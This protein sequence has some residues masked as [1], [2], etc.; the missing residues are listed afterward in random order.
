MS[1]WRRDPVYLRTLHARFEVAPAAGAK[2]GVI[3]VQ[4]WPAVSPDGRTIAFVAQTDRVQL[5]GATHRRVRRAAAARH[6]ERTVA[7]LVA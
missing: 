1:S 7:V 3:P 2:Y 5:W 6:H 4:P